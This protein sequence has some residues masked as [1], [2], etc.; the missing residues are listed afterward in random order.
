MTLVDTVRGESVM[1]LKQE[2]HIDDTLLELFILDEKGFSPEKRS[3]IEAHL[4]HC[5]QCREKMAKLKMFYDILEEELQNPISENA[6]K[7]LK[8]MDLKK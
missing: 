7:I 6:Y 5:Q 8:R 4:Q 3:E 1:N 2:K